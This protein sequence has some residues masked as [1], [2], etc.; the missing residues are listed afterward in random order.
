M[1]S[2]KMSGKKQQKERLVAKFS[3][4]RTRNNT[5]ILDAGSGIFTSKTRKK[6]LGIS[7]QQKEWKSK[8]DFWHDRRNS[9]ERALI[10]LHL[11]LETADRNNINQVITAE[12]LRPVV[13]SLLHKG[14][15]RV[16]GEMP[17]VNTAEIAHLF[18]QQ[19]FRCL[20][21]QNKYITKSHARTIEEALDLSTFLVE[22]FKPENERLLHF[23][24]IPT[25]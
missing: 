16:Y 10:D 7:K 1:K 17:D 15:D 3:K 6:L 19:G 5:P 23:R 24:Y 4:I 11:F 13:V 9:V 8:N 20:S 22:T 21:E 14:D 18:I 12:V 2:S 25:A